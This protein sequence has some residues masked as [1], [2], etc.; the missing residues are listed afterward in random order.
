MSLF[1]KRE[2]HSNHFL[3][4]LGV[5]WVVACMGILMLLTMQR[6][7]KNKQLGLVL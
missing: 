2:T 5:I 4:N 3:T 1:I 7:L 6:T